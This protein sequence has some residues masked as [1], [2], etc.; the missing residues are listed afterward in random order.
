MTCA[1]T[2]NNCLVPLPTALKQQWQEKFDHQYKLGKRISW[3]VFEQDWS[4][5]L[6]SAPP[7]SPSVRSAVY[8][9]EIYSKARNSCEYRIADGLCLLLLKISYQDWITQYR[10]SEKSLSA[11]GDGKNAEIIKS[12][13][14][15]PPQPKTEQTDY[16]PRP[17][18]EN[19]CYN[20]LTQPGSLL[21]IKG[22]QEKGKTALITQVLTQLETEGYL[23]VN[24]SLQLVEQQ[25]FKNLDSFLKWFYFQVSQELGLTTNLKQDWLGDIFGSKS[26]CNNYFSQYILSQVNQPLI[27]CI[28]D[29]DLIFP[30][31]TIANEFLSLLRFWHEQARSFS[32]WKQLRLAVVYSTEVDVPLNIHPSLFNGGVSVELTELTLAEGQQLV[33][34]KNLNLK[35]SEIHQSINLVGGHPYLINT[36]LLC[37]LK[38]HHK[39]YSRGL[40]KSGGNKAAISC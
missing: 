23:T 40:V 29:L 1:S 11:S 13:I 17:T 8:L 30:H 31:P 12:A 38:T 26:C 39:L 7:T 20:T 4:R 19:I 16:I 18:L 3:A 22:P 34:K 14:A 35:D 24:L 28:D 21:Q 6:S 32:L 15:H 25:Q 2:G 9:P 33:N 27:L 10:L 36:T 37:G 5:E